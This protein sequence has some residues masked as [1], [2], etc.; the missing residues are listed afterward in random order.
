[1]IQCDEY[2]RDGL[3]SPARCWKASLWASMSLGHG[4][5]VTQA[6]SSWIF[7]SPRLLALQGRIFWNPDLQ[8]DY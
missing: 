8:G 1:M 7:Q 6:E 2:F 5:V 4:E 3:K